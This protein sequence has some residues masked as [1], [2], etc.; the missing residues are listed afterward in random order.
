MV[1]IIKDIF[2][3]DFLFNQYI[4]LAKAAKQIATE[5]NVSDEYIRKRLIR[6]GIKWNLPEKKLLDWAEKL[7]AY[8]NLKR[9][10]Y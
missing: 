9:R 2:D 8:R 4:T 3:K 10:Q 6:E 5:N 1:R 7:V